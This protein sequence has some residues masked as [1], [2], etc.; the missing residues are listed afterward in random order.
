MN[1]VYSCPKCKTVYPIDKLKEYTGIIC[2]T[3]GTRFVVSVDPGL[4]ITNANPLLEIPCQDIGI[5]KLDPNS[6]KEY[7][8]K[9][10]LEAKGL[11]K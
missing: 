9:D 10:Y 8:P 4:I 1:I 2:S 3:C 5:Y 6:I 11:N 7:M